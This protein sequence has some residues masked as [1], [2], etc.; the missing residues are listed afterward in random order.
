[1]SLDIKNKLYPIARE[2]ARELRKNQTEAEKVFWEVVRDHRTG[3]KIY[4]QYPIFYSNNGIES[5]FIADF[6]CHSKKIIIEIDGGIHKTQLV[7][8]ELRTNLLNSLGIFVIRFTNE[9]V[10]NNNSSVLKKLSEILL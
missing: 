1:M 9:E 3:L 7:H 4:R 2:R 10:M 5:F 8:D 6:Y